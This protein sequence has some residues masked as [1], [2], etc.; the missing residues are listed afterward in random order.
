MNPGLRLI[1]G[2]V[3]YVLSL[4]FRPLVWLWRKVKSVQRSKSERTHPG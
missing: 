1:L 3:L 2:G 4:P